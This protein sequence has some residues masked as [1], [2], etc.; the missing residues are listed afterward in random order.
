MRNWKLWSWIFEED[1]FHFFNCWFGISFIML[2]KFIP[3]PMKWIVMI[4]KSKQN[5][6]KTRSIIDLKEIDSVH[7][8]LFTLKCCQKLKELKDENFQV[9]NSYFSSH[10]LTK[11]RSKLRN[12]KS[13][14]QT[15]SKTI[16][17]NLNSFFDI[18]VDGLLFNLRTVRNH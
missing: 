7:I 13:T 12:G 18:R 8:F 6:Q 9:K 17:I 2:R 16:F 10:T 11:F 5:T 1:L 14:V 4:W 15:T 3:I